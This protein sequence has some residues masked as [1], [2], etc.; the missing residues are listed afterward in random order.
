MGMRVHYLC[1]L[2]ADDFGNNIVIVIDIYINYYKYVLLAIMYTTAINIY[3]SISIAVM[4]TKLA[5]R[6]R[7]IILLL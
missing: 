3:F 1:I 6:L 5:C 2:V 4:G 7:I